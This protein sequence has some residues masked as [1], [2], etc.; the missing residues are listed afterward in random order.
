MNI[1]QIVS[2]YYENGYVVLPGLLA[3]PVLDNLRALTDRVAAKAETVEGDDA[4]FDFDTDV[5]GNRTIQRIKKPNRIDPYYAEQAGNADILAVLT[6]IIGANVRLSHTKINMK[7]ANGGAALEWH[8]DW[9]F[10]PHTNMSTCVASVMLD[11]ANASNGAMQVIPG[12][13]K[14]PLLDHH[15]E[16]GYFCGAVDPADFDMAKAVLLEGPPGTVSFH[17]PMTLHGSSVN[18]SGD[19]RR[20]LFYEYAASDAFPLFYKVDW[21][22][23]E[24]R[25]VCGPSTREVR[26]EQNYVRLPFPSRAGSSI[27]KIQAGSKRKFFADA[28]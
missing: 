24:S 25:L 23:Y 19:P 13:H 1:D 3:G 27:Y 22:E 16:E 28:Q 11:G 4:W 5:R 14:G 20:I 2:D 18:R 12:S 7:S 6:R 15:D 10:A 17:H 9:A 26:F 21:D 8:Q